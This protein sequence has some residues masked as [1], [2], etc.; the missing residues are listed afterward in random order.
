MPEEEAALLA[1]IGGAEA[2][3]EHR[4]EGRVEVRYREPRQPPRGHRFLV[5]QSGVGGVNA[6]LTATLIAQARPEVDA[7]VLLGVG[8][9]LITDLRIGELV[10]STCV[11]QH[12]SFASLPTGDVRMFPG[13]LLLTREDAATHVAPAQADPA[14]RR[15][16]LEA[17][18]QARSG[19]VLS[20]AEFVGTVER[21]QAIA[22]LHGEAL[23]VDM[24]AAGVAQIARRLGLPFVVA[25][26]VTDRLQPD[27]T[28]ANDFVACL[29]AAA[30]NAGRVMHGLLAG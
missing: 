22:A 9:A 30:A 13:A 1:E 16:I 26:T 29:R 5:A 2:M 20:G 28:I 21:K 12:D 10:V 3:I 24:E 19:A 8:G 17:A 11:L 14:L 15:W 23:L 4:I 25:K 18:P 7:L 6:A 27:G